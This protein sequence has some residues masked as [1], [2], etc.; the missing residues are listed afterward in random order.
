MAEA[1]TR[2]LPPVSPGLPLPEELVVWEILVRL[3]PKPLLRCRL[4]CRAWRRL[5]STR[6]F[7]L[8]HHRHQPSL[9]L[10]AACEYDDIMYLI[11]VLTLTLGR[12]TGVAAR[13]H[14]VAR[15]ASTADYLDSS[16]DGLL[17]ISWNTG[18]P[19][20]SICNP[21]TRQF[22]DLPLISGFMFLGLYQHRHTGDYRILLCRAEKPVLE[23]VIPGH[24]ERDACYVYTLGSN[25]IMPRRI[26]WAEPEVSVLGRRSRQAQLHGS[27][28]HWYHR[29]KHMILVF[30]TMAESFRWMRAPNKTDNELNWERRADLF[31]MDSTLGLYCCNH[32]KTIVN[33]WALQDHEQE[34]W[35][36]KYKVKLPVTCIRGELDMGDFWRVTVSSED[37]VEVVLLEC[38][39]SVLCIDT[40]G[41]LLACLEHN[42]YLRRQPVS[43][44]VTHFT[45]LAAAA[46]MAAAAATG[47]PPPLSSGVALPEVLV[48]W[49]I[50][51]RLPPKP[52]LRC[53]LVCRAWRRLTS[54]RDFLL[55]HH[56]HQPSLPVFTGCRNCDVLT[57]DRRRRLLHPV[58]RFDSSVFCVEEA[59]CDG[60]L[61]LW[62]KRAIGAHSGVRFSICNPTT[63]QSGDI[64]LP[65][66]T[67][68]ML[69][70]LYRHRPTGEYRLLLYRIEL[71]ASERLV[72]VLIPGDRNACY[73]YTLGSGD[74]PRCI[75]WP[76]AEANGASVLL[77]GSL[78]WYKRIEDMILAFDITAE[79]FR[80]MRSPFGKAVWRAFHGLF[81]IN[82][83]LGMYC[84]DDGATFVDIWVLE[85]YER[86]VWSLKYR[87]ELPVLE[88]RRE[89]DVKRDLYSVMVSS[90]DGDV[91]VLVNCKRA[92]LYIGTDGKL[93]ASLPHD[94]DGLSI[95]P[96]KLRASLVPH[97]FFPSLLDYV[98]NA[99]PFSDQLCQNLKE[100]KAAL[101]GDV[102]CLDERRESAVVAE[103]PRCFW[104]LDSPPSS[105]TTFLALRVFAA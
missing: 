76:E 35:S 26:G 75:G 16:R 44:L 55:A 78:H 98:V 65:L 45:P 103:M 70:G 61:V 92:M 23:D 53:R 89:L 80:W 94:N 8:A 50:L 33:I 34:V 20:Y 68:F 6:D 90:E 102:Y 39:Q 86:E 81:E 15:Y 14:P 101:T 46:T 42:G 38:G 67:G 85:D 96:V 31:E 22:G 40:D 74:L 77:H 49:D 5:T 27:L 62:R 19:Q 83:M 100:D 3:P 13:L 12:R 29:I 56:R 63:R 43:G 32:G 59:S 21:T 57:V 69:M 72:D 18:P 1:A 4:V 58:A 91:L 93:L 104:F 105:K 48:V 79:S 25:D 87:V 24:V 97:A 82:C 47:L 64:P 54:T 73:V 7:L 30:D 66:L 2:E 52:L 95:T 51:V 11:D 88:I 36:I 37:G 17:L 99:S 9:P 28:L 41:K 10:I 71:P 84:C 60:I